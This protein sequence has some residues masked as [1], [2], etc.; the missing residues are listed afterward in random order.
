MTRRSLVTLSLCVISAHKRICA[1][2][3]KLESLMSKMESDAVELAA[4]IENAYLRRCDNSTMTACYR[5]N[6]HECNSLFPKQTCLS[7]PTFVRPECIVGTTPTCGGLYDYTISNIRMSPEV[8]QDLDGNP[9]SSDVKEAFCYSHLFEDYMIKKYEVDKKYWSDFGVAPPA[10]FFGAENGMFRIYPARPSTDEKCGTFDT[11]RRPWYVAATAGPKDVIIILDMSGSMSER[12]RQDLMKAAATRVLDTL[13][14]GDHVGIIAFSGNADALGQDYLVIANEDN[15]AKLKAAVMDL[16]PKGETNYLAAFDRAFYMIDRSTKL[17]YTSDCHSAILFLTDGE[18]TSPDNTTK[19]EVINLIETRQNELGIYPYIFLYGLGAGAEKGKAAADLKSMACELGGMWSYIEDGGN[20]A[21]AMANY[22]KLFALGLGEGENEGF[23]AWVDPYT[24][25]TSGILGTT[26]SAPVYDRTVSP[27]VLVGAVGIDF[28]MSAMD[29][30]LGVSAASRETL[31]KLVRRSTAYCPKLNLSNCGIQSLRRAAGG[32]EAL[33]P[34]ECSDFVGIETTDCSNST[35]PNNSSITE[36]LPDDFWANLENQDVSFIDRACCVE[37]ESRVNG[38]V[39]PDWLSEASIQCIQDAKKDGP[40]IPAGEPAKNSTRSGVIAGLVAGVGGL[41]LTFLVC[42]HYHWRKRH[43]PTPMDALQ[44][45]I[46]SNRD[47]MREVEEQMNRESTEISELRQ[48][49]SI[50]QSQLA[51]AVRA[52]SLAYSRTNQNPNL[53]EQAKSQPYS[54]SLRN[55]E[56]QED[57]NSE[58][59]STQS[60]PVVVLSVSVV[61]NSIPTD[62]DPL[63]TSASPILEDNRVCLSSTDETCLRLDL[64]TELHQT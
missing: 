7:A 42:I 20:L 17:E 52:V 59:G 14:V 30:A 56:D 43:L 16:T 33:C 62:I 29:Q 44:K 24:F 3:V 36:Y 31:D 22:Y 45:V 19:N 61:A 34:D 28:P 18:M 6:F 1:S 15:K 37:G 2:D 55:L 5:S 58:S 32:D 54:T 49:V 60:D 25:A 12:G 10:M 35:S 8:L 39:S 41:V 38:V 21:A 64:A 46:R 48:Q 23:R 50:L 40:A 9:L 26:V 57:Y 27:S 11:T 53:S 4:F 47:R 63:S 51:E 13:S